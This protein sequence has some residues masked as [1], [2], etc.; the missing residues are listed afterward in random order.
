M[1]LWNGFSCVSVCLGVHSDELGYK[2]KLFWSWTACSKYLNIVLITALAAGVYKVDRNTSE[3]DRETTS[4]VSSVTLILWTCSYYMS[5]IFYSA[6]CVN[7]IGWINYL[8]EP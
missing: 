3:T 6:S 2:T 1:C 5:K 7:N 8:F 4:P